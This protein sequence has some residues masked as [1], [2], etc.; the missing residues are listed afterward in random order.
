MR[1]SS[2]ASFRAW[3]DGSLVNISLMSGRTWKRRA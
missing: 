3:S 1:R 2:V